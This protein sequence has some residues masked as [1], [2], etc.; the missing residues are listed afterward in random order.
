MEDTMKPDRCPE[1][2]SANLSIEIEK[3][4]VTC[5]A[6]GR[7]RAPYSPFSH[8]PE[9]EG[10][11]L[12]AHFLSRLVVEMAKPEPSQE[13]ID[14]C[15]YCMSNNLDHWATPARLAGQEPS[16]EH[17]DACRMFAEVVRALGKEEFVTATA[18]DHRERVGRRIARELAEG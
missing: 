1:C 2:G 15:F 18:H 4:V 6:C 7:F 11:R 5:P 10:L 13:E 14:F 12:Y 3:G 8:D 9:I 17:A 16:V